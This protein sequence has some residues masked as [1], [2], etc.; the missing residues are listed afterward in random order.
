MKFL[1]GTKQNMTQFF[2]EDGRASA[3]TVLRI[4]PM[5]VT[6]VKG[7]EKD[8][9][10]AIQIGYGTQK[11]ERLSKAVQGHLK[12]I[13]TVRGMMEVRLPEDEAKG[14]TRGAAID[15]S[16]WK[17]GDEVE[18]SAISKGKGF[19]GVVKRHGFG[20]GRRSHG[21]KHSE[22]EAGSIGATWP[23]RVIKNKRMPGRMGGDRITVKNLKVLVV[24]PSAGLILISGAIPGRRG[25]LVEVRGIT[26]NERGLSPKH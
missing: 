10:S 3:G 9:Y 4:E 12:D 17:A 24:D 19:Q 20:G 8:G 16:A 25:T 26:Q 21:Q 11:K 6:Q 2:A 7:M 14:F 13:A 22:R 15:L 5:A 1:I 23:Q 18:V